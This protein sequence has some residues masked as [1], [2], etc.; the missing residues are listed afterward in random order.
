MSR[1]QARWAGLAGAVGMAV[2]VLGR[3]LPSLTGLVLVAYGAW[4]AWPPAGF[5]TAGALILAD[6]I[7][8]RRASGRSPR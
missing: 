1:W 6:Q 2:G 7:A 4:L 8:D 5:V 3:A